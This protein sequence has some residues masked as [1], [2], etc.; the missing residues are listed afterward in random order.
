MVSIIV[1]NKG[2][3]KTKRLIDMVNHAADASRGNVVCVE[4]GQKL[5]FDVAHRVRLVDTEAYGINSYDEYYGLL[6]GLC[7]G[8][9]DLTA[10]FSAMPPS[11]S[12]VVILTLWHISSIASPPWRK[13]QTPASPLPSPAMPL[14]CLPGSSTLP[15]SSKRFPNDFTSKAGR[16]RPAFVVAANRELEEWLGKA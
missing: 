3:G 13:S 4:K 10:I 2:S 6:S 5:T 12:A 15:R 16:T 14:S 7:A 9:Y 1:G 11:K 8:N